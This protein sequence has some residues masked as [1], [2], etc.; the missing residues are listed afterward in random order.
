MSIFF[1]RFWRTAAWFAIR[2][3]AG[4]ANLG[5]IWK[6]PHDDSSREAARIT[7][8]RQQATLRQQSLP[9]GEANDARH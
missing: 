5:V 1:R 4:A 9:F 7:S 8:E 3:T 6:M 2:D